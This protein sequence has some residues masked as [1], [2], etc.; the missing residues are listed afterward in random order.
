[1]IDII[2]YK[3]WLLQSNNITITCVVS[4]YHEYVVRSLNTYVC[5][6]PTYRAHCMLTIASK[7]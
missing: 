1:M 5:K 6:F 4:L 7:L 3:I 2:H